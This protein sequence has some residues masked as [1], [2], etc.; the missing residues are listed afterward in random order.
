MWNYFI[1]T[2]KATSIFL[3]ISLSASL[4]RFFDASLSLSLLS[5][6][7][8]NIWSK[9]K[10]FYNIMCRNVK[11]FCKAVCP[12][13]F[14]PHNNLMSFAIYL[15]IKG[16]LKHLSRVYQTPTKR[17][18][19]CISYI[20]LNVFRSFL[21]ILNCSL[22]SNSRVLHCIRCIVNCPFWHPRVLTYI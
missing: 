5:P 22:G 9:A 13:K 10:K 3:R 16:F 7:N 6:I 20:K 21:K 19:G 17:T 14:F 4:L 12:L 18:F 8:S 11:L 15:H 2:W 1:S